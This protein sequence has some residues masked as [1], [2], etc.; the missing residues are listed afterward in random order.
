MTAAE[1]L[2]QMAANGE[3]PFVEAQRLRLHTLAPP[4]TDDLP[5]GGIVSLNQGTY[6]FCARTIPPE[7]F[8]E[9]VPHQRS[10]EGWLFVGGTDSGQ[11]ELLGW[12]AED[13]TS[14][15]VYE[16]DSEDAGRL[17]RTFLSLA[18]GLHTYAVPPLEGT[19]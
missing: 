6:A 9:W 13:G 17:R 18:P 16:R 12:V 7:V 3:P 10:G 19:E 4:R 11:V 15:I 8:A 14:R 2:R 5:H 1:T